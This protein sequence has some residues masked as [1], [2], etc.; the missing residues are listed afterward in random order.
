MGQKSSMADRIVDNADL[1]LDETKR[2]ARRRLVGAIVLALAAAIILPMLLEK[3]PRPL[4][5]DVSV[6]IPPMDES[7]FINKLTGKSGDTKP[8][9]KAEESKTVG[10]KSEPKSEP[11]PGTAAVAP[12]PNGAPIASAPGAAAVN[13]AAV[14]AKAAAGI[15]SRPS[16]PEPTPAAK[17][18]GSSAADTKSD[19]K[20]D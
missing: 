7:K 15:E 6:K 1:I 8:L 13:D 11:K 5:D 12:S 19:A 17:S 20:T 14:P 2:K 18:A 3:E 16:A 4:G 10:A 9:P